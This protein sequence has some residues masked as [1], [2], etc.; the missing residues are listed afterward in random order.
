MKK[1]IFGS[2][3]IIAIAAVAAFNVNLNLNLTQESNMSPLA[4]ANVEALAQNESGAGINDENT[5]RTNGGYWNMALICAGGGVN[6][7]LC[8][9]SG[10]LTILG[11]TI[12]GNFSKGKTYNV[13]WERWACTNSTGNCCIASSQGVQIIGT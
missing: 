9:V 6:S 10:E 2:L 7:V 12:K 4:L 5:C 8:T 11:F 3:I 1:K 13:T